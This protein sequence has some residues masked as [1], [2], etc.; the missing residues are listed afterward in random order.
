MLE[1]IIEHINTALDTLRIFEKTYGL[2]EI[3]S[4]ED[5]SFPAEYCGNEYKKTDFQNTIYHRMSGSISISED[6]DQ[7]VSGCGLYSE[8]SYPMRLVACVKKN[9]YNNGNN[10]AYIDQKI[11]ENIES[12]ISFSNNKA[13]SSLLKADEVSVKVNSIATNRNDIFRDEYRGYKAD[14]MFI[15][16]EYAYVAINYTIKIAGDLSCYQLQQC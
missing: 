5:K 15:D 16:Y 8:R 11:A 6:E 10:D 9:I 12:V 2:C 4:L 13:L 14:E 1:K 7:Q 3:I